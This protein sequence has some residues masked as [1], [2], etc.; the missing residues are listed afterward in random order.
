[1][2]RTRKWLFWPSLAAIA[3]AL[4]LALSDPSF[5]QAVV[6]KQARAVASEAAGCGQTWIRGVTENRTPVAMRVATTGHALGNKW[7]SEP[8]D[9]VRS[10]GS[11]AWIGGDE[12]GRPTHLQISYL[13]ANHDRVLFQARVANDKPTETG[14]AFVEVVRTP[15]EYECQAEIVAGGTGIA[16]VRFSVLSVRR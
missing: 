1:M 6:V 13:L 3:V 7:C 15:R 4:G 5:N 9:A 10:H 14:C 2:T 11:S 12:S 8:E 16:F